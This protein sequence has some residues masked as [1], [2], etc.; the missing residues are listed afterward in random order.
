MFSSVSDFKLEQLEPI[1]TGILEKSCTAPFA[2]AAKRKNRYFD[3][4]RPI[5]Q[6]INENYAISH[7]KL[8][9]GTT[10]A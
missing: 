10:R 6:L 9:K 4:N 3:K 5:I 1:F 8:L 2:V 7:R